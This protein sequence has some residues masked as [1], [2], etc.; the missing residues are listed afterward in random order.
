MARRVAASVDAREVAAPLIPITPRIVRAR[1][2]R[3]SGAG[4]QDFF[5]SERYVS[6]FS[7]I[8]RMFPA[9]FPNSGKLYHCDERNCVGSVSVSTR[10]CWRGRHV[11]DDVADTW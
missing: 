9:C 2:L 6:D 10:L 7:Q 11:V 5:P 1:R 4:V 8:S 3:W